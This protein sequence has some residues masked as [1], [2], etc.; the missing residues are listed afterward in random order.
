MNETAAVAIPCH[1]DVSDLAVV[2]EYGHVPSKVKD[3]SDQITDDNI[4][5]DLEKDKKRSKFGSCFYL[6]VAIYHLFWVVLASYL[7][8]VRPSFGIILIAT[9]DSICFCSLISIL[10]FERLSKNHFHYLVGIFLVISSLSIHVLRVPVDSLIISMHIMAF[11]S[12]LPLTFTK[13]IF[14]PFLQKS[15][16]SGKVRKRFVKKQIL[17]VLV[18]GILF[19]LGLGVAILVYLE[20]REH[21][22]YG[23][24]NVAKKMETRTPV[25]VGEL[26][27]LVKNTEKKLAIKGSGYSHAGHVLV[28]GGIQ[29]DMSK[30]DSFTYNSETTQF[31]A[32]AGAKW[33]D[34]LPKLTEHGRTVVE[35]QSYFNFSVGGSIS[36]N[37][38]G[39][40][41]EYG[42]IADTIIKLSVLTVANGEVVEVGPNDLLFKAVVGGYSMV[43]IIVSA[44]FMTIENQ[45]LKCENELVDELPKSFDDAIMFNANW[46]PYG[47]DGAKF[48]VNRLVEHDQ[49]KD[50]SNFPKIK[51]TGYNFK[52]VIVA[53][54]TSFIRRSN[55]AKCIR[56]IY[57]PY[58]Q[59]DVVNWRSYCS[60]D[61]VNGLDVLIHKPR[62]SIL[63]EYFIPIDKIQMFDQFFKSIVYEQNIINVS[64]RYVKATQRLLINYAPVE[65]M[66]VVLYI[67]IANNER[68]VKKLENWTKRMLDQTLKMGGKF[69]LPYLRVYER[70]TI[71]NM[72]DWD[73]LLEQKKI[74]DPN[75]K[76]YNQFMEYLFK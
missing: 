17:F 69:Y 76:I 49:S 2:D 73:Q 30:L 35:M 71:L 58:M 25:S 33:C 31:T 50:G 15:K 41:T 43:G 11:L 39:R 9:L 16:S 32:Q 60:G 29:I 75:K 62:S 27:G 14:H 36:V 56:S 74:H 23:T 37:C 70:N 28:D 38:H 45:L 6:C 55:A 1:V 21:H 53:I 57:D 44:T 40:G 51:S 18:S 7:C 22:D 72:Y 13:S 24:V 65:T 46:Y 8:S 54:I 59:R 68:G 26:I 66:A 47:A 4:I 63:Q 5:D 48:W 34:I 67:D 12:A 42:T 64:Y 61:S 52:T 20:R 10:I 19:C 3:K